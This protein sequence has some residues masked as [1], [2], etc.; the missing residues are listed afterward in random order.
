LIDGLKV[1]L[2][3][4]TVKQLITSSISSYV[5]DETGLNQ[6]AL[7]RAAILA[8]VSYGQALYGGAGLSISTATDAATKAAY[9]TARSETINHAVANGW[10]SDKKTASYILSA[11]GRFY[12]AA[13]TD[14]TLMQTMS[15]VHDH[16]FQKYVN[17]QIKKELGVDLKYEHLVDIYNTDWSKLADDLNNAMKKMVPTAG[18]PDESFLSKMGSNFVDEMRRMP[19]NFANI[20]ENV[21]KELERTPQNLAILA[22]RVAN[23]A[24]RTPENVARIAENLARE[25]AQGVVNVVQEVARTPENVEKIS[26]NVVRE[27]G[28]LISNVV[29]EVERTPEN[30]AEIAENV[31]R[32]SE[33]AFDNVGNELSKLDVADLVK[34]YGPTVIAYLGNQYPNF[35]VSSG[36]LTV[37]MVEDVEL[38]L[39]N[40]NASRKKSKAPLF[41][42]AAGLI[43]ALTFVALDE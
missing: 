28:V 14:Q 23:E 42:G 39:D 31:A 21:L 26:E 37:D 43:A 18:S 20:G 5:G 27:S 17:Y 6:T 40:F 36:Q 3:T 34:Q 19:G 12:D 13:G 32:E 15:E 25:S 33:R 35:N 10:V 7:G 24:E 11:G 41:L 38:N 8:G 29:D 22:S 2:A 1:Y 9:S 16:E 4:I 30:V